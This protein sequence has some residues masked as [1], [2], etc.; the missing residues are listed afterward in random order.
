MTSTANP[1]SLPDPT[2]YPDSDGQPMA[3]NPLQFQWIVLL[4]EHLEARFA[5]REDVF[6]AGDLLW[7]PV[8]FDPD[9]CRVPDA[10]AVFG[11]PKGY[12]GSSKQW[13]EAGIAPQVVFEVLSPGNRQREL[14]D[15]LAVYE[16]YG[17]QEYYK[18]NPEQVRLRGWQ[19]QGAALL[20]IS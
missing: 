6:V 1:T 11:R 4:K 8:P 14:R 7:Y 18:Y 5:E 17:G 13:L 15:T 9:T 20:P 10:T 19:R 16:Q 3:D 2:I 12:R